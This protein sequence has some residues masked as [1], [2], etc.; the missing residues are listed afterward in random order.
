MPNTSHRPL[1]PRLSGPIFR[2]AMADLFGLACVGIGASWFAVG[3]GAIL[4]DFPGSAGEAAA[5]TTGG[6]V[7]MLWAAARILRELGDPERDRP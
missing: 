5:C 4:A 7:V 2:Y 6:V 1:R 3:K